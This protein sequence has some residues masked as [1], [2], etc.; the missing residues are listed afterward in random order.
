MAVHL[1]GHPRRWQALPVV[2]VATFMALFDAYVANLAAPSI[3]RSLH[4]S[5]AEVSLAVAAYLFAFAAGQLIGGRLG[6]RYGHRRLFAAGMTGFALTSAACAAAANPAEL[7]AARFAQGAAGAAM[8]PQ[9]LALITVLFPDA[10]ERSRAIG[11]YGVAVGAGSVGG[12]VAGGALLAASP[13]G[14]GWRA[15]F[16]VNVP[17][18]LGTVLC[19]QRLI[20]VP[21]APARPVRTEPVDLSGTAGVSAAVGLLVLP[22]ALGAQEGWPSCLIAALALSPVVFAV[23][24]AQQRRLLTRGGSPLVPVDLLGQ[25]SFR[26][27]V[28]VVASFMAFFGA[29]TLG[30]AEYLQDGDGLS[31]LR[32]GLAFA[33]LGA[34]F[35]VVSLSASGLARRRGRAVITAGIGVSFA[36]VAGLLAAALAFPA[37]PPPALVVTLLAAVGAG[38]GLA[39]PALYG[40]ALAG[41][42]AARAGAGSGMLS[43]AQQ[44][45]NAIGV[46]LLGALFGAARG[47]GAFR[48]DLTRLLAAD[49]ALLA[50]ALAASRMFPASPQPPQTTQLPPRKEGHG[51]PN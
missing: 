33:P 49:L 40:P 25:R 51:I 18:G 14:L 24:A 11:W 6:D 43:T 46:G 44:F 38:N 9:V 4:A 12:Q 5:V 1:P 21:S 50:V 20:P 36:A 17:I 8:V 26:A 15:L 45:A 48:H 47:G 3:Q 37:G 41:V 31:P 32:A 19:G 13:L 42:P 22:L 30:V 39:V 7:V 16:L 28:A 10:R 29:F 34:V 23:T 2:L 35:A 27:G